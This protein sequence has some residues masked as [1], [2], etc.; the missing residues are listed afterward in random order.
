MV[1]GKQPVFGKDAAH[2]IV[3]ASKCKTN[4]SFQGTWLHL[5]TWTCYPLYFLLVSQWE[6]GEKWKLLTV[7]HNTAIS[8]A[9]AGPQQT[10]MGN[11]GHLETEHFQ[12]T[13]ERCKT[14]LP[15]HSFLSVKWI[16]G[17]LWPIRVG[18]FF[19]SKQKLSDF[20]FFFFF[21]LATQTSRNC[22]K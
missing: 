18:L 1:F 3:L 6:P 16:L 22:P 20:Y 11:K 7:V 12:Q 4:Q 21:L 15:T 8:L 2:F 10:L 14:Y 17:P 19:C 5:V 13:K 9:L